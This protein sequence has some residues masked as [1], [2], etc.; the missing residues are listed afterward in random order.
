MTS[1]S[2]TKGLGVF[3]L[4]FITTTIA[5]VKLKSSGGG[6]L[7]SNFNIDVSYGKGRVTQFTQTF[8][9]KVESLHHVRQEN[10]VSKNQYLMNKKEYLILLFKASLQNLIKIIFS[11]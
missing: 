11:P 7:F 9:I 1:R 6:N 3:S 10:V 8:L 2:G 5:K 4:I